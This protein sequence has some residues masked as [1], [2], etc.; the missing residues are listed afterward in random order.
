[1]AATV[2]A[3]RDESSNEEASDDRSSGTTVDGVD[4]TA[5]EFVAASEEV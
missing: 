1:M 5:A 4:A 2:V 3:G